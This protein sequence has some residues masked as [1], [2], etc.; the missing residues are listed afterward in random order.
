M[1]A[2]EI[3]DTPLCQMPAGKGISRAVVAIHIHKA[4]LGDCH[5]TM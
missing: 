2:E 1:L 4:E 3:K 5:M